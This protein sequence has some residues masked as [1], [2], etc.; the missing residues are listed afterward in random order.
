MP[1]AVW[2]FNH[3]GGEVGRVPVD[4]TA[5]PFRT[6]SHFLIL[7]ANSKNDTIARNALMQVGGRCWCVCAKCGKV[8]CSAV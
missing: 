2:Q 5:V 4:A 6:A 1:G 7:R 8:G 3:F